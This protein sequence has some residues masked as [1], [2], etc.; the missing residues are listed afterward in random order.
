MPLT[1]AYYY[2][3]ASEAKAAARKS[4]D[5]RLSEL[6]LE[7]AESYQALAKNEEWLQGRQSRSASRWRTV[8]ERM[9][10][11]EHPRVDRNNKS[12]PRA[13]QSPRT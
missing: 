6:F 4:H 1:A 11:F 12:S 5:A 7:I 9:G 3:R 2:S 8:C 13:Q 10:A